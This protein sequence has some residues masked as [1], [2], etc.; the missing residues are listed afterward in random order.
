MDGPVPAGPERHRY[1]RLAVRGYGI[2]VGVLLSLLVKVLFFGIG[3]LTDD[4]W[5]GLIGG[6]IGGLIS[7]GDTTGFRLK[8]MMHVC[9]Q[10]WRS[11]GLL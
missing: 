2:I 7:G 8:G 6:L 5:F 3:P 11:L 10:R 1:E 9:K 4:I